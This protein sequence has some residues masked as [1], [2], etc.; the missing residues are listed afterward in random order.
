MIT[1]KYLKSILKYNSK[2]GKFRWIGSNCIAGYVHSKGYFH[3]RIKGKLYLCHRLA[4]LYVKGKWP[5]GDLDHK[6]GNGF[7]NKFKNLRLATD[8][9]NLG[10]QKKHTNNTSGVKGVCWDKQ[11]GRWMVRIQIKNKP[12]F[13]GYVTDLKEGAKMYK[14]A[15]NKYFKEFARTE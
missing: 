10:N 1:Q 11:A 3:I 9:Q 2:T 7:N 4:W 6:D 14:V 8:S 5:K 15:A 12:K 13:L